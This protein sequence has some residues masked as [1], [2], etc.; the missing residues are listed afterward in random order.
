MGDDFGKMS[1]WNFWNTTAL[2]YP[3]GKH[4]KA[5]K[6]FA[7]ALIMFID[8]HKNR[9]DG[10]CVIYNGNSNGIFDLHI[11]LPNDINNDVRKELLRSRFVLD[12]RVFI[13]SKQKPVIEPQINK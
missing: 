1:F 6:K 4:M 7:S 12:E 8:K 9:L 10:V 13:Y 3:D 2:P 5:V 11:V